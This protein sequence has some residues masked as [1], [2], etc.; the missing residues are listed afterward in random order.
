MSENVEVTN[1]DATFRVNGTTRLTTSLV[2]R[3]Y[4]QGHI[5]RSN[6]DNLIASNGT[7]LP[8]TD[9][10]NLIDSSGRY[11]IESLP[12]C[13]DYPVSALSPV[14]D[15]GAKGDGQTDD[16]AALQAALFA[17]AYCK[18]T[19]FPHGIYLVTDTLY[20]P[21]GSRIVGQVWSM[22]SAS[23]AKFAD[24]NNPHVMLQVGKEG[25]VSVAEFTDMLFTV[26]EVLRGAILVEVNMRGAN[27][28]CVFPQLSLSHWWSSRQQDGDCLPN[29]I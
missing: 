21:P 17:N 28:R 2:G 20:V 4:V 22:I 23:G 8:Y 3:T 25:E 16:T 10:G 1:S 13:S 19:Y 6:N 11:F 9:R 5:Y 29:R 26:A 15:T 14:K 27:R 7:F 24:S 18:V 12:Q